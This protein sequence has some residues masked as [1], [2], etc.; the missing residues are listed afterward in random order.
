[1]HPFTGPWCIV[2]AL[3]GTS[4]ELK[5]AHDTKQKDKKHTSDLCPYPAELIPFEPLDGADNHYG[6][7]YKPVG[8]SLYKE[9]GIE[10]FT[11]PQPLQAAA[12]FVTMGNFCDFHFPT[13]LELNDEFD[14]FPWTDNAER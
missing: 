3:P 10:G 9:A 12:H 11:P 4:Y 2:Q 5:F 13:L 6:Q 8:P 14:S 7:L 1:M